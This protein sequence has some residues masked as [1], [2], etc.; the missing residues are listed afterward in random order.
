MRSIGLVLDDLQCFEG[1]VAGSDQFQERDFADIV[2]QQFEGQVFVVYG[3]T[4]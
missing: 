2:L 4:A 3:N 1:V